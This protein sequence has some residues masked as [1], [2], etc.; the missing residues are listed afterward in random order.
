MAS[1]IGIQNIV[2]GAMPGTKVRQISN[3]QENGKIV[4]MIGD[5]VNDA[6]ALAKSDLGIAIGAGSQVLFY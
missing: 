1:T 4:A 5:G 3:L 2:A 6:P